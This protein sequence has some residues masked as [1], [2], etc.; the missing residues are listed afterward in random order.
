MYSMTETEA[1]TEDQ[2]AKTYGVAWE[3]GS[4]PDLSL[5]RGKVLGFI[6]RLNEG[7]LSLLHIRDAVE[8]FVNGDGG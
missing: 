3:G 6:A 5:D 1:E 7:E 8:D 4:I 2:T